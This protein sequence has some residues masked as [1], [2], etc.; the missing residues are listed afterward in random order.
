M[1]PRLPALT[2]RKVLRALQRRGFFIHHTTGSH[3]YLKHPDR[4]AKCG[5]SSQGISIGRVFACSELQALEAAENELEL[6]VSLLIKMMKKD[7]QS[8]ERER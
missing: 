5:S 2:P 1:N 8:R 6:N 4:P 3:Y 7:R